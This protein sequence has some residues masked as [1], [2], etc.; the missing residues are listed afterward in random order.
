MSLQR[1]V[2]FQ[3]A[4]SFTDEDAAKFEEIARRW[5]DAMPWLPRVRFARPFWTKPKRTSV[6]YV[7]DLEFVDKAMFDRYTDHPAHVEMREF[8]FALP[9]YTSE[10]WD[11]EV[12]AP[13]R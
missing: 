5:P 12:D 11:I 13:W 3:F 6:G 9:S 7:L 2:Y 8:L 4:D 1:I 10:I